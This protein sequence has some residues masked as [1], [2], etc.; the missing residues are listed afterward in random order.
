MSSAP[1]KSKDATTAEKPARKLGKRK[2]ILLAVPVALIVVGAGLW[3]SG[4]LP[5]MLGMEKKQEQA[6]KEPPKPVPPSYVDLPEM[7][8]NLNGTHKPAY[9]KLAARVEVPKA[10][11]VDKVKAAMPRLQDIFQTYLREMRPEELR[12]SAGTYRLREELLVRANAAVAP[13]KVSDILFT[14]LLVQ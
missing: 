4:I 10:E 7:I 6:S 3:F 12:G 1:A 5:H 14:Q 13:A 9:I 11:D 2:L 8:A